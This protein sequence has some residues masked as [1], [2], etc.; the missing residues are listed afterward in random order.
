MHARACTRHPGE[1]SFHALYQR[2]R[3]G[4]LEQPAA[5]AY[6]RHGDAVAPGIDDEAAPRMDCT[7]GTGA[8]ARAPL[9]G[10]GWGCGAPYAARRN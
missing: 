3:A 5:F 7:R 9:P 1:R 8:A 10:G 2:C 4:L 6:L